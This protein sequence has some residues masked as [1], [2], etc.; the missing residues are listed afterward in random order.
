MFQKSDLTI[1]RVYD[2]VSAGEI[3][4]IKL[5]L[6]IWIKDLN[7]YTGYDKQHVGILLLLS[8]PATSF[9]LEICVLYVKLSQDFSSL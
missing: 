9:A 4:T 2:P 6:Y 5:S 7:W 8:D 1:N 3:D